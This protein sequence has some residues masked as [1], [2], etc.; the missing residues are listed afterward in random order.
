M[1]SRI[2]KYK[3]IG[4]RKR[5]IVICSLLFCF[6]LVGSIGNANANAN[7][8]IT[9]II[10]NW[11]TNKKSQSIQQIESAI[12]DEK[13]LLVA[14]LKNTLTSEM[15]V[16]DEELES[17]TQQEISIRIDNLRAH[18]EALKDKL[19]SDKN[20]QELIVQEN[21]DAIVEY[22]IALMNDQ[23]AELSLQP[24]HTIEGPS[25]ETNN[26]EFIQPEEVITNPVDSSS[27]PNNS[28]VTVIPTIIP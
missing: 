17:Y 19:N 11:F 15:K 23:V 10:T 5:L 20:A 18:A 7:E 21:L 16:V 14:D 26:G 2:D 13:S 3:K 8:D 12:N 27:S 24:I 6:A 9:S 22:A 4:R 25:E 1:L 28:E